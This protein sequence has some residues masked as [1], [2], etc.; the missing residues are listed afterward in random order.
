MKRQVE[1]P[2]HLEPA[3][4]YRARLREIAPDITDAD[5]VRLKD[6]NPK[7]TPIARAVKTAFR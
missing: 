5:I 4:L 1:M 2:K 7:L 3:A 6:F